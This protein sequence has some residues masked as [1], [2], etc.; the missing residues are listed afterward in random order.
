MKKSIPRLNTTKPLRTVS[1]IV[2]LFILLIVMSMAISSVLQGFLYS[3]YSGDRGFPDGIMY[4]CDR[5]RNGYILFDF[6]PFSET[7][8]ATG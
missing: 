4:S 8:P 5:V 7:T 3:Y 6:P 2:A 1:V